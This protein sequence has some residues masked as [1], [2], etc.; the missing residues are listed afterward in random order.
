LPLP[1]KPESIVTGH[2]GKSSDSDGGR[3]GGVIAD[4]AVVVFSFV[5]RATSTSIGASS[6]SSSSL[7]YADVCIYDTTMFTLLLSHVRILFVQFNV[8]TAKL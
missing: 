3:G 2:G 8:K 7:P 1:R 5:G 6:S 4:L